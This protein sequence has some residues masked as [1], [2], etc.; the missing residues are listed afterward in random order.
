[1]NVTSTPR[2]STRVDRGATL[3]DTLLDA[4][5][6]GDIGTARR[7]LTEGAN[8]CARQIMTGGTPLHQAAAQ[9]HTQLAGVLLEFGCDVDARDIANRTA[10]HV[11]VAAGNLEVIILLI[12]A[13]ADC[14]ARD[15]SGMTALD[16][17]NA[18]SSPPAGGDLSAPCPP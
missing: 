9:G 12:R 3:D 15:A 8:P 2:G 10:L 16:I 14:E 7:L 4:A 17:A 11:E 1:M 5:R 6:D 18:T 13:G